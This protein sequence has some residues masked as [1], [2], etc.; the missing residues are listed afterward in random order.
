[1][2]RAAGG[3]ARSES[4]LRSGAG[5]HSLGTV[6]AHYLPQLEPCP[7]IPRRPVRSCARNNYFDYIF[8]FSFHFLGLIILQITRY[9]PPDL[10][11]DVVQCP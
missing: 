2:G 6:V 3:R 4:P 9:S 11:P 5:L 10:W 1:M 7:T 8:F